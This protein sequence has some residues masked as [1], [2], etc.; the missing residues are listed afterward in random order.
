VPKNAVELSGG[1]QAE[2]NQR[3]GRIQAQHPVL[4][5]VHVLL[6][7][8]L[9]QRQVVAVVEL[10]GV[11]RGFARAGPAVDEPHLAVLGRAHARPP[12]QRHP[13]PTRGPAPLARHA[14]G[15]HPQRGGESGRP[16][17]GSI[18]DYRLVALHLVGP[19]QEVVGPAAFGGLLRKRGPAG[20][21]REQSQHA[22]RIG[23]ARSWL[24]HAP[25]EKQR[26][27]ARQSRGVGPERRARRAQVE[28]GRDAGNQ[29]GRVPHER[30]RGPGYHEQ[31]V[32]EAERVLS[33]QCRGLC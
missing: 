2:G 32:V 17:H 19:A 23:G 31:L 7:V 10:A 18:I 22:G 33:W 1:P 29:H 15:L 30:K 11:E 16:H 20:R 12:W 24:A 13:H 14:H 28:G 26:G 4:V 21:H 27:K 5:G 25:E 8:H 3:I 9:P 6:V